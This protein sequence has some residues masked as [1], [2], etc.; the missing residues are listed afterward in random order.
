MKTVGPSTTI[1]PSAAIGAP[2]DAVAV[3]VEVA[4]D[5]DDADQGGD[6]RGEGEHDLEEVAALAGHEGLHDHAE[7]RDAE[8]DQQ[9]PQ[10]GVLDVRPGEVG[11]GSDDSGVHCWPPLEESGPAAG[12]TG[13]WSVTPAR[14]RI[15][16]T[17]G[18]LTSSSGIG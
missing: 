15:V 14:C 5:Q 3:H 18:L 6:E 17:A 9:R 10:Q 7:A 12:T 13:A 8:D 2:R 11:D 1:V 4:G 16:A